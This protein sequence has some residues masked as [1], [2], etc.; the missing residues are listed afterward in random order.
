MTG[1]NNFSMYLKLFYKWSVEISETVKG[2]RPYKI[3]TEIL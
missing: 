1:V 3:N 2:F